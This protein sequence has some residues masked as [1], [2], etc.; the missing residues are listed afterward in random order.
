MGHLAALCAESHAVTLHTPAL[1]A[2]KHIM[3]AR[4]FAAMRDGTVFVNTA[5]GMCVDEMA[6]IAELRE[7]RFFAFLDVSDPEPAAQDSPLRHLPNV[8]YTS[9]MAGGRHATYNLGE[10]CI[11]DVEAFIRGGRPECVVTEEQLEYTA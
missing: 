4:E 5:R 9:H 6:L 2:T 8:V 10:Q 11:R 3:G 1:P 7:G